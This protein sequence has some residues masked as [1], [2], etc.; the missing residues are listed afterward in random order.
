MEAVLPIYLTICGKNG[1]FPETSYRH[2]IDDSEDGSEQPRGLEAAPA[3]AAAAETGRP[4]RPDP[5][6]VC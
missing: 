6:E 3:A 2:I 4:A 1:N 5:A